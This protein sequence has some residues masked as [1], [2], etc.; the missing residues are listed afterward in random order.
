MATRCKRIEKLNN[1]TTQESSLVYAGS[2]TLYLKKLAQK[3]KNYS[4]YGI[5]TRNLRI[6]ST[7]L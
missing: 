5:R 3:L 7:T 6:P 4:A 1:F 2:K